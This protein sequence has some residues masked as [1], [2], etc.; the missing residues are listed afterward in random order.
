MK[1]KKQ[2][3]TNECGKCYYLAKV[4]IKSKINLPNEYVEKFSSTLLFKYPMREN[5]RIYDIEKLLD[6][7]F[8]L[9]SLVKQEFQPN[10][11]FDII[12]FENDKL[13]IHCQFDLT[14]TNNNVKF[15]YFN[16]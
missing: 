14:S 1:T 7:V 8:Y 2:T 10:D 9:L 15:I 16:K 6:G 4:Y 11:I 13:H 3:N 5:R 12:V